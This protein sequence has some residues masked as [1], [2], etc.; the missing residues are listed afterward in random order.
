MYN[1]KRLFSR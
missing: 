1:V